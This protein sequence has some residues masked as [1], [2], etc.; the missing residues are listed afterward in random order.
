MFALTTAFIA[1][2]LALLG[3][4]GFDVWGRHRER[5]GIAGALAGEIGAYVDLLNPETT[6]AAYRAVAA[7]DRNQRLERLRGFPPLPTSHPVFDKVADKIGVLPYQAA[8]G[9]SRVYNVITGMRLALASMSA[10]GFL[11]AC[12]EVQQGRLFFVAEAIEQEGKTARD[13]V[14]LLKKVS[15]QSLWSFIGETI[16]SS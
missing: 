7:L 15:Q 6:P 4:I 5:R 14:T 9:I 2:T 13:V 3:K 10:A 8:Y 11:E 1:A 12:D 16:G